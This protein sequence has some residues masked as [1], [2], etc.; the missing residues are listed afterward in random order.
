MNINQIIKKE[1]VAISSVQ[2]AS[3]L[4]GFV[5]RTNIVMMSQMNSFQ[6][7]EQAFNGCD[8]IVLYTSVDN[9][10]SGHW[11]TMF[12][13]NGCL[14]F[15]DSYGKNPL[16]LINKVN[17][18]LPNNNYNQTTKI[19]Q[20]IMESSYFQQGKAFMNTFDYQKLS[21]SVNDCGRYVISVLKIK[22]QNKDQFNFN[23]YY[24]VMNNLRIKNNLQTFDETV[25][26]V[27]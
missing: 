19:G 23:L 7:L 12:I 26:L 5:S 16:Y 10:Y 15:Y 27:F 3:I 4:R 20:L 11:Q 21:P 13:D 18:V 9:I 17:R 25:S 1:S 14:Y 22:F 24:E 2:M 8:H 6:T